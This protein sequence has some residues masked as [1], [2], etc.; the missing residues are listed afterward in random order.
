MELAVGAVVALRLFLDVQKVAIGHQLKEG[1]QQVAQLVAGQKRRPNALAVLARGR[2]EVA[3]LHHALWLTLAREDLI[4]HVGVERPLQ[5]GAGP[6][7]LGRSVAVGRARLIVPDGVSVLHAIYPIDAAAQPE[8]HLFRQA[9][10]DRLGAVQWSALAK[11]KAD[12][13]A[14]RL[15][16][17]LAL[18][19]VEKDLSGL[20]E[21]L[22]VGSVGRL[23]GDGR[24]VLLRLCPL[25][26]QR[27]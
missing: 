20:F 13:K 16:V 8:R 19:D 12:F 2:E 1:L 23:V 15:G 25:S 26:G 22:D 27:L 3:R 18:F 17:L 9:H 7:Q 5:I 10:R 6:A 14:D 11:A 24:H 4:E 21:A